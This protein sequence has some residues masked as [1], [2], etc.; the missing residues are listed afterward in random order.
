MRRTETE[1]SREGLIIARDYEK[2][3]SSMCHHVSNDAYYG[4]PFL[5][6]PFQR[7][8]I[9]KPLF[10]CGEMEG[11]RFKRKFRRAI[12]GL[13]SGYGKTEL[14]AAIIMT[15]A[16]M[17]VVHAGQYGVVASSKDQVYNIF[18]KI[19]T[20]IKLNPIWKQQ[21]EIGKNVITN[22][23]TDAKIMVLP[24]KADA[25][26]SWHYN[27]L[28]FDEMHV[29]KDS[30]VWD[31]GLKGQKVLWNPL[32]I[33]ITTAGDSREG[34]LWDTIEKADKD[35]G[36]YLYWL[37]MDDG[38]DIDKR[39]SWEP[40]MVAS[41]VTWE[42]IQDQRGMA[43]SKRSF[44]R[45]TANRFPLDKDS[46]SCFTSGEL[47]RCMKE[48]NPFDFKKPFTLGIDGAT[49]GDSFA[50][51]AYQEVE[52]DGKTAALTKEWVFDEPDEDT[53]HYDMSQIME[54]IAGICQ[55]YYPRV[56]GID[57]NRMIVMDSQLRD[58]YGIKT[59]A[60]AQ[61]NA[62]MCQATALVTNEV[63][64]GSLRLKG[65]QKL[66]DHLSNTVELERE[67]YGTR[68]G[69]DSKRSKI[70]AAIALAIACLAYNKLVKGTEGFVPVG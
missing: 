66:R 29:Y 57:P 22:K 11:G 33:G 1:Y 51:V 2:C 15:V 26:E 59:V 49:A 23:E 12:F 47:D 28:V 21:W 10:A 45:Y 54:L 67:P 42:S 69:K 70:D 5:L 24:N 7:E 48:E 20:Q 13:P 25:L 64:E 68:F 17:E 34:F 8:N 53:G 40:L 3:L 38:L 31:A 61:N 30:K 9:W 43:T 6:E 41:W 18:E 60:F 39:E 56:V 16:T 44:E 62:T 58:T 65:C 52:D 32:S 63:R 4:H 50:I 19:G 27:V 14:A 36:L 55:K 46:Y 37:G 35:P